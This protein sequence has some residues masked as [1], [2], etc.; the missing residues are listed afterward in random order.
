M[1]DFL[2]WEILG[3][4]GGAAVSVTILTEIIKNYLNIDPKWVAL[5][6]SIIAS[7]GV[8]IF[9]REILT[10]AVFVLSIF[11]AL[12]IAGAS[13]GAYEGIIK[14]FESKTP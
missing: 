1:N 12:L 7:F 2:T 4:F 6:F 13:I 14:K 8:E 5:A 11:N 9:H 3:T 10:P